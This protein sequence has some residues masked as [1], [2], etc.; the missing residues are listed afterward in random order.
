MKNE[1][2]E[3]I[4]YHKSAIS[5]LYEQ[6]DALDLE[7]HNH[8][9]GRYFMLDASRYIRVDKIISAEEDKVR[10]EGFSVAGGE[11]LPYFCIDSCG[12]YN[13]ATDSTEITKEQFEDFIKEGY[14]YAINK[15]NQ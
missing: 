8:L 14:E 3:R 11:W 4:Q 15:L 9:V 5:D 2:K 1:L 13:M 7:S 10:V 6:L 12:E